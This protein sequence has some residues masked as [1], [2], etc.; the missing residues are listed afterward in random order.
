MEKLDNKILK[1]IIGNKNVLEEDVYNIRKNGKCVARKDN[2]NISIVSKENNK[3][4]DIYVKENTLFGIIHIPVI[5]TESGLKDVVEN[6]FH[7]GKNSNI[8]IL[9]GCGV[10]N[11]LNKESE[12]DGIHRFYL[13][14]GAKVK[15]IEK[16]YAEGKGTGK[17]ILSPTTEIYLEENASL[18]MDTIQIK[19]VDYSER[20]TY[21]K[22]KDKSTLTITEKIMTCD[23]EKA[24]TDF[25]ID[26]EGN[27]AS[28]HV[29]SR[30]VATDNSYQEFHSNVVGYNKC[31]AHVECD[32]I[33]KDEGKIR[34]IPE[35]YAKNVDANLVH[36]AAIGKIAK[37]QL[38]KL[39]SLG[40]TEKE[41]ENAII[42]GFLK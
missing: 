30:S 11:P 35:I 40:L 14:E 7:I 5:I 9:S 28:C 15:Y 20:K 19:G 37:E 16:H 38:A 12:H 25:K 21:A 29:T 23:D 33:I 22:L 8:V 39:M 10:H 6:D 24:I 3:G 17:K 36:E 13:E 42:E 2:P 1:E 32:A 4:L 31:Y 27:N 18:T 41:A 34:A 26:L